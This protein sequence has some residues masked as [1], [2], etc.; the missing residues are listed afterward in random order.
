MS[1]GQEATPPEAEIWDVAI[2]G[3]GMGGATSGYELARLGLR[4][5]FIEKGHATS[6]AGQAGA[7]DETPASRLAAGLWPDRLRASTSFGESE[8]FAP[9]G[10]GVGG[11]TLLYAAAL[12]R[13]APSDFQPRANHRAARDSSVP[14]T[15]PVSYEEF[16]PY[17][18]RAEKLFRVRGT[19]DPLDTGSAGALLPPPALSARDEHLMRSFRSL[20]LHPYRVHVGC[21]FIPACDGCGSGPCLA[22]CKSD[23][24]RICIRPAVREHGATVVDRCEVL[25][26]EADQGNVRSIVCERDGRVTQIRAKVVVLAAGAYM[27]PKILLTSRSKD[28]PMGLANASGLVGRNLMV[29][30]SDFFALAPLQRLPGEGPQ[31]CLAFND[32]Y[33]SDGEKLGTFQTTGMTLQL[34]QIMQYLRDAAEREPE[35]WR[36]LATPRPVWYRKVTSPLVR[37]VAAGAYYLLGLKYASIWSTIV[38]DLPYLENRVELDS[39]TSAGIRMHYRYPTELRRRTGM[40]RERL[41]KALAPHRLVRLSGDNNL[42]FGH[43]CGTCRFGNDPSSSV[44]DGFNRAHGLENLFVLDASFFPSSGGTNPSLT[45][46]ANA[47]RVAP[48]IR[49]AL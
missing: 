4:V 13:F 21:E 30:A 23:A 14:E 38:E 11:S 2:V 26:L 39:T 27:T 29:H 22:D 35:W 25:R 9:L 24:A 12:E 18:E 37:L 20:G 31:K 41:R 16:A 8:F 6:S 1:A 44:L 34:G 49:A 32:F 47:L 33:E 28:W 17:Y 36:K 46:A 40:L 7:I 3:T 15:W 48:A 42:N 19:P 45:I 10:C 5:L 43:P